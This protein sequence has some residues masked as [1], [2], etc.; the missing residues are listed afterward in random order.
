MGGFTDEQVA[1]F[2]GNII[3]KLDAIEHAIYSTVGTLI[4]V[5]ILGFLFTWIF[6]DRRKKNG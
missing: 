2:I 6:A 5:L 1:V 4:V 3:N